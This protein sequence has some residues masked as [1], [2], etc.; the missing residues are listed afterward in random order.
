V[1]SIDIVE[2]TAQS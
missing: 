1:V 2:V